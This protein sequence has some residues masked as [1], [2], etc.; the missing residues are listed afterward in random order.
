[1]HIAHARG[2][3]LLEALITMF[4]FLV[5]MVVFAS[6]A[7]QYTRILRHT[8]GKTVLM[9]AATTSL[10]LLAREMR[11][12]VGMVNPSTR[13]SAS[14]NA[15]SFRIVNQNVNRLYPPTDPPRY[16][17]L[18]LY[19]SGNLLRIDYR[20]QQ[21]QLLR[22]VHDP[23]N[24]LLSS[25]VAGSGIVGMGCRWNADQSANVTLT[26]QEDYSLKSLT[27]VVYLQ[28]GF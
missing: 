19:G 24:T 17:I 6:L 26:V 15:L 12:A 13:G 10:E 9:Q 8:D 7:R 14:V 23:A 16:P 28:E 25:T 4:L 3:T 18:D 20:I 11:G 21:D 2:F 1:M 27:Q 22:E 5:V